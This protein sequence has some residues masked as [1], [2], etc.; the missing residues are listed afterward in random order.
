MNTDAFKQRDQTWLL[1]VLLFVQPVVPPPPILVFEREQGNFKPRILRTK[2][3]DWDHNDVKHQ[4]S[5]T[6]VVCA[7]LSIQF[8]EEE[9][10]HFGKVLAVLETPQL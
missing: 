5:Q 8:Q 9:K 6:A 4:N 7:G 10:E 3:I 2:R 1:M